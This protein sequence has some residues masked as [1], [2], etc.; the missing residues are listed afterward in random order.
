MVTDPA[1]RTPRPRSGPLAGIR[2]ADFCWVGV[3][4]IATRLLADYGAD[5]IKIEHGSRLD[6]PRRIPIYKND[7][8][9]YGSEEPYP[10]PNKGGLF[11]NWSRNKLGVT[12]DMSKPEGIA[13][14]ERLIRAS[15]VVTEN[16]APGVMEKWGL[17]YQH[18]K[19]L[20]PE[21]IYCRMSGFGH[22]GPRSNYRSF[23]PVVQAVSGLSFISGLP[24]QTPSGW[25]LSYMD[26]QAAYYGSAGLLMAVMH[27]NATGRG[28]EV[29]VSAYEVGVSIVGPDFLDATVNGRPSRRSDF[30]RGNRL[31]FPPAAPHGVYPSKGD[32]QWVAIA[33]TDDDEWRRLIEAIGNPDWAADARFADAQ[34]RWSHQDE[35]DE[36]LSSWTRDRGKH[37][38]MQLL[39]RAGVAAAAAQT[40]EDLNEND[41]QLAE[42]GIF[43]ELDHPVIGR[44]RFEGNPM[45]MSRIAPDNWRSAP[46]LGEDNEYVFGEILGMGSAERTD[47]V[48]RG[49]I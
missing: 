21:I 12:I 1:S 40:P 16:F 25:G 14:A 31:E 37:E 46:L 8:R 34:A 6:I 32:D 38:A 29:D 13:L 48:E 39:Q 5:V 33:V 18:L 20:T 41:D 7:P 49:I 2:V 47:L 27:R 15:S 4:S 17:T 23:G 19:E 3:G 24:G 42:R 26:N 44:S 43:F 30:P 45:K 35:L 28:M 11:N 9:P 22:S 36:K 10:D